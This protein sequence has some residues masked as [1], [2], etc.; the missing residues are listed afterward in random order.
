[1]SPASALAD[2]GY[3]VEGPMRASVVAKVLH[4]FEGIVRMIEGTLESS[5]EFLADGA[6]IETDA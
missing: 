4:A 5:I 2:E 1:M 3:E 6:S